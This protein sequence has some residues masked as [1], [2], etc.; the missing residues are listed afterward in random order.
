MRTIVKRLIKG[1]KIRVYGGIKK[2]KRDKYLTLNLEKIEILELAPEIHQI[3]PA[4]PV[5]KGSMESK[6]REKG[7][8]C[9]KCKYY[10]RFLTKI[11][12]KK[13]RNIK[14]GVHLPST[15]AQR[16]LTKP[17]DRYGKEK[18]TFSFGE[19]FEPWYYVNPR[20]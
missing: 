12:I 7:F 8:K 16:H 19:I 6:G 2:S 14:L 4:C 15:R 10:D 9:R 17:I 18:G 20:S 5:C 1:D 13:D 11:S 3:N